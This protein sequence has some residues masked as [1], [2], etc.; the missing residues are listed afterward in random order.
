MANTNPPLLD[1]AHVELVPALSANNGAA[2]FS[3]K[4]SVMMLETVPIADPVPWLATH[5]PFSDEVVPT[6][7]HPEAV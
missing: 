6:N 2:H 1:D 3:T 5:L 4:N 7:L